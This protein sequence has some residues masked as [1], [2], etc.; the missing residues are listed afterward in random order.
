M[1]LEILPLIFLG[2]SLG[3]MHALDADH[4][5][6]VTALSNQKPSFLK[7][8]WFSANWAI[9]HG[10][11]LLISGVLLFGLGLSI[12]ASLQYFS[13]LSVGLLLIAI[14]LY[15]FWQFK[16]QKLS[17]TVHHHGDIQ[18]SHW[19]DKQHLENATLKPTKDTHL[20]IMVGSLHGLAGSAPAL[21]LIPVASQGQ[22]STVII[23]LLVFSVGV[24]LSMMLFGLGLG[25]MQNFLKKNHQR[26]Q[27]WS[28][29]FIAST[30]ML[31][32]CFWLYKAY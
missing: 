25:S 4:V 14:G 5:M 1:I 28:Q 15:S 19:H 16:Q 24:M 17:M 32:G 27:Y 12:P 9:G 22:M 29:L 6:A 13:E 7:T 18:H 20:P 23:Y 31:V 11:V 26:A 8:L 10:G 21:A 3:L 30:S 2:F